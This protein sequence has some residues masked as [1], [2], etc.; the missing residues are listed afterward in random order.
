MARDSDNVRR[1]LARKQLKRR[2]PAEKRTSA[3]LRT[4]LSRHPDTGL[5]S[6]ESGAAGFTML[7]WI[8]FV[9]LL[10]GKTTSYLYATLKKKHFFNG[11]IFGYQSLTKVKLIRKFAYNAKV[12]VFRK[13]NVLIHVSKLL[14]C[15]GSVPDGSFLVF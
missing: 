10:R 6:R 8:F 14:E 3:A 7:H 15:F 11:G 1:C 12:T 2:A 5:G 4:R 9:S 13:R